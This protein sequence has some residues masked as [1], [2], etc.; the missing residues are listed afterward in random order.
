M[1]DFALLRETKI[2]G[3]PEKSETPQPRFVILLLIGNV[4]E[5][6]KLVNFHQNP[7]TSNRLAW[8]YIRE[9]Y[10]ECT[11]TGTM[12]LT[13]FLA[14]VHRLQRSTDCHAPCMTH[15]TLPH[16]RK[17]LLEFQHLSVKLLANTA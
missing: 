12:L 3:P 15:T 8:T 6:T 7:S 13:F 14:L 11:C 10:E 2:F 1:N 16:V 5:V 17:C 9:I 4:T